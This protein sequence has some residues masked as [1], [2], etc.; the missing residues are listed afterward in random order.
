MNTRTTYTFNRQRNNQNGQSNLNKESNSKKDESNNF[1]D[2]RRN[3]AFFEKGKKIFGVV[4]NLFN[5]E[6]SINLEEKEKKEKENLRKKEIYNEVYNQISS[7]I[8]IKVIK[9]FITHF[10]CFCVESYDV[11][12]IISDI[13]NKFKIVGEEKKIKYFISIFNSNMYSI[14]NTKFKIISEYLNK[15]QSNLSKFMNQNYLKGTVNKNNKRKRKKH[16][17]QKP[18][19]IPFQIMLS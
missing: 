9:D 8:A 10:S 12:D 1:T 11:I 18:V 13:T 7:D 3:S 2:K 5:R 19:K 14:K 15:N 16:L 6:N 17:N 4:G